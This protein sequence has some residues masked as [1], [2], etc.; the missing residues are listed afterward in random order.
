MAKLGAEHN[1]PLAPFSTLKVGGPARFLVTPSSVDQLKT[2]QRAC[3]EFEINTHIVSGG[4]NTLFSDQGF[5]GVVIK[6]ASTF[7]FVEGMDSGSELTVGAA[8]SF[9]R[10]TKIATDR[11]WAHA[12]GWS[13]IPG[14]I[15]GAVAMNAGTRM[16]EIKDAVKAV[17]GVLGGNDVV[18]NREDIDFGYRHT[19]LPH[20]LIIWQVTLTYDKEYCQPVHNLQNKLFEYR[21]QRKATQPTINSLGSFFRNPYPNYAAQLI[22]NCNLKGLKYKGAQIS[23]LHANFIVNNGGASANDILHIASVAK[24]AVLDKFGI[25]L[26]PEVR[27]VGTFHEPSILF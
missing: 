14:L 2:L 15:G 19:S 12:V 13:G 17:Y 18:F 22:E 23:P 21:R 27:M 7:N 24:R 20:N 1:V 26:I 25:A 9:A 3:A 16:G 8:T 6:L 4:S 5:N 11:G 10:V